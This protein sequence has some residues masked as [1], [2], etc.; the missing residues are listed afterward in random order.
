MQAEK[1][2]YHLWSGILKS[3]VLGNEVLPFDDG[4]AT[5]ECPRPDHP[6]RL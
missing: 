4:A 3:Y 5:S 6:R 2:K 1:V